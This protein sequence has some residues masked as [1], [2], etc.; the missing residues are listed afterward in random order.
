VGSLHCCDGERQSFQPPQFSTQ[1]IIGL[2]HKQT[3]L[4]SSTRHLKS[5]LHIKHMLHI[6]IDRFYY[7]Y[8]IIIIITIIT[9]IQA[10][11]YII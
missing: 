1:V 6:I 3:L 8:V 10:I 9:T 4:V 7:L 2:N 5:T 11:K